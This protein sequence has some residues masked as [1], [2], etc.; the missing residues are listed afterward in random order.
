MASYGEALKSDDFAVSTLI[1]TYSWDLT[2]GSQCAQVYLF[3]AKLRYKFTFHI[4][5]GVAIDI[6]STLIGH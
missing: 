3:I 5:L 4:C 1:L 6:C 2:D